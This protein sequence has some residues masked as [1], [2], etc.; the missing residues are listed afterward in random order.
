MSEP[1]GLWKNTRKEKE[2]KGN[3]CPPF[4]WSV[5]SSPKPEVV[6]KALPLSGH[7]VPDVVLKALPLSGLQYSPSYCTVYLSADL[8]DWLI[9]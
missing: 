3:R 7:P 5:H 8:Q 1:G 9:T 4:L 6:L 2:E